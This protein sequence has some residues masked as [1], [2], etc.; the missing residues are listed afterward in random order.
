MRLLSKHVDDIVK[1]DRIINNDIIG[2]TETLINLSNSTCKITETL[3]FFTIHFKNNQNKFLSLAYGCRNEVAVVDKFDA[4]GVSI[5]SFKEHAFVDRVFILMLVYGKQSLGVQEF[6][7]KMQYLLAAYFVDILGGDF[8]YDLLKVTENKLSDIFG[9]H[10]QIVNKATHI[11]GSL[12]DHEYVKRTLME[13]LS[14][15][16][17]VENIY[18]LDNDAVRIEIDKNAV[19]F[20]IIP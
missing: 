2:F 18:F 17:T 12:I 14:I 3:N 11:P 7:Q 1:H 5:F 13:E 9:D 16:L 4:N 15:N 8:N 19:D 6:S 10:V 20:H